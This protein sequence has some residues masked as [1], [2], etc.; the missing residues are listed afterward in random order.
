MGST[1]ACLDAHVRVLV[2]DKLKTLKKADAT[3]TQGIEAIYFKDVT[4]F[5]V[6]VDRATLKVPNHY[7]QLLNVLV[8]SSGS[9]AVVTS[10]HQYLLDVVGTLHLELVGVDPLS[11]ISEP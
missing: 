10:P 8:T 3:K 5:G 4:I 7:R 2:E 9:P 11:W 1:Q 6:H